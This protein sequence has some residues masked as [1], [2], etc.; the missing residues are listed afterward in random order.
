MR[1]LL[2][3]RRILETQAA[4]LAGVR[5]TDDDITDLNR[6]V[7]MLP[8]LMNDPEEFVAVD[9]RFY[10]RLAEASAN[11]LLAA[12]LR[13]TMTNFISRRTQYPVGHVGV[14]QA[15]DNQR[16]TFDATRGR[17]AVSDCSIDRSTPWR[18]RAALL[19][20]PAENFLT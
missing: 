15:L 16:D 4:L 14:E 2:E 3:V 6:L 7:E 11:E 19:G 18:C 5:R 8:E 12:Y 13:D 10:I 17:Y 9:I 20:P 1:E